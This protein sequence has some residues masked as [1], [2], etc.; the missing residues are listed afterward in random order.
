MSS[1]TDKNDHDA[2]Y[3]QLYIQS[4]QT[5]NELKDDLLRALA[6]V[7]NTKNRYQQ[8]INNVKKYATSQLLKDLL[9]V[10]DNLE[11]TLIS[12][13]KTKE[14][15]ALV[16]GVRL[17]LNNFDEVLGQ[18]GVE[19]IDPLGEP[20]NPELHDAICIE[21]KEGMKTNVITKVHQKGLVL[22]NRVIRPARVTVNKN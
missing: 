14:I 18:F 22:N 6:E 5:I 12:S 16:E 9:P 7:E 20:F 17:T 4:N 3:K 21:R 15:D 8:E 10:R 1:E 2:D 11:M 19:M 13:K